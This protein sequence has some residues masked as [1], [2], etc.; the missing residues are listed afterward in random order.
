V[1]DVRGRRFMMCVEYVADKGTRAHVP[2]AAN[3]SRRIAQLCEAKGLLVRPLGHLDIMSPP[4]ILTRAQCDMLVDTLRE[5][6][7]EVTQD[8]RREGFVA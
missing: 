6:I 4:L 3:M 7:T 5:A 1:G 2:E 8:L